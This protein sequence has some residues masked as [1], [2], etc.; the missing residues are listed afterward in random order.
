MLGLQ[1][2]STLKTQLVMF[3]FFKKKDN[4]NPPA[5]KQQLGRKVGPF[6]FA[7]PEDW[8][9]LDDNGTFRANKDDEIRLT[10][11]MWDMSAA[12][13]YTL[14]SFFET[15]K[16]AYFDTDINWG[17]YSEVTKQGD[18][19]FQRLEYLD[20]PRLIVA[21]AERTVNGKK[22]A[23]KL[24]FAGNTGAIVEGYLPIFMDL[25]ERIE[26]AG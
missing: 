17:A 26:V 20:D 24:I 11:G 6:V 10:I 19:I 14:A 16:S 2:F 12:A 1:P 7:V 25:L 22:I 23:L 5:P 18:V 15:V 9:C 21:V 8:T 3:N 4:A 13:N